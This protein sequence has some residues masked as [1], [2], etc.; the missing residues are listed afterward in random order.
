MAF[1]IAI[2]GGPAT[3]KST[4]LAKF[5]AKGVPVFSADEEVRQLVQPGT[6]LCARI[7]KAFGADY[8]LPS[9]A[10]NRRALLKRIVS[11]PEAKRRL[12][13]LLHPVVKEKLQAFLATHAGAKLVAA[14]IPLLYEVGWEGLFDL[15]L[16]VVVPEEVQRKRLLARIGDL[17]LVEAFLGLQRPLLEKCRRADLVVWGDDPNLEAV[18]SSCRSNP[19][20]Q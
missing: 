18:L 17:E 5:A 10:L 8:F 4:V 15:V 7:R 16:V 2:T 20:R 13:G 14:E 3:G 6:E 9:G 19:S 1:K 11:D 12:E